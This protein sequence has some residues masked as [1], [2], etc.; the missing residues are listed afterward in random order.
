MKWLGQPLTIGMIPWGG[1]GLVERLEQVHALS[2][3]LSMRCR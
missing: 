1:G 2:S 3:T